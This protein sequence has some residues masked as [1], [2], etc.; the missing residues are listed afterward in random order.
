MPEVQCAEPTRY[1]IVAQPRACF[2]FRTAGFSSTGNP[3]CAAS[4]HQRSSRCLANRARVLPPAITAAHAHSR[5][6]VTIAGVARAP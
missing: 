5:V 2:A 4:N 6:I 1:S 3:A